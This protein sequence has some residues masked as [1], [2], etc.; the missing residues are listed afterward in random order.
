VTPAFDDGWV[1]DEPGETKLR[2]EPAAP[3]T[4]ARALRHLTEIAR[5]LHSEPDLHRLLDAVLDRVLSLT[6]AE[7]AFLVLRR[8]RSR[9]SIAAS[10]NL[11]QQPIPEASAKIS[12]AIVLST[13]KSGRP[14]LTTNATADPRFSGSDSVAHMR[15]RAVL[16]VPLSVRGRSLGVLYLDNRFEDGAFRGVRMEPIEAFGAQAA[17]AIEHATFQDRARRHAVAMEKEIAERKR[18]EERLATQNAIARL[19]GDAGD[20]RDVVPEMVRILAEGIGWDAGSAWEPGA[21]GGLKCTC[22]WTTPGERLDAFARAIR[23][24]TFPRGEGMPG[25]VWA[26]RKPEWC[27]DVAQDPLHP[28]SGAAAAGLRAAVAVPVTVGVETLGVVAFLS[29]RAHP[30]DPDL[31]EM[32]ANVGAQFG[33][34]VERKR[35]EKAKTQLEAMFRQAQKMDA[36]G[37]LAGG[38]A[39]DFNNLLTVITGYGQLAIAG[40]K[41]GEPMHEYLTEIAEAARRSEAL[42]RQLLVFSRQQVQSVKVLNP[43]EVVEGVQR[44]LR[45]LLGEDVEL[46]VS[47]DRDP[48]CVRV[49]PGQLEQVIV[50]LAVNARDAMPRGGRLHIQTRPIDL[51]EDYLKTR[52]TECRPGR[53]VEIAVTDSGTGIAPEVL[54][55]IFEP[56]FTTKEAGKGTGLGLATVYG[57]VLQSGGL[58]SVYSE[59]GRGASFK[60]F[61]PRVADR[62]VGRTE[63][64]LNPPPARGTESVLVVE[65]DPQLRTLT[66]RL[67]EQQGYRVL[68][69]ESGEAALALAANEEERIDLLLTDLVMPRIG[70]IELGKRLR[71]SRPSL[72]VMYTSGYTGRALEGSGILEN[73][74]T[75][76]EKPFSADA[77][78]RQVRHVL[79]MPM[80]KIDAPPRA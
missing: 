43:N 36:I 52:A 57:I 60:V 22:V 32:L 29:R 38:V 50:N 20:P 62:D 19:L 9:F 37:R 78:A 7:R 48:G 45:R 34:F 18:A 74:D 2:S 49:D 25:R 1:P 17:I 76:I 61:L 65:D 4:E 23:G 15:L 6:H 13:E 44:M 59:P 12:R 30:R 11:D 3:E 70:G 72:R 77:L 31:L 71:E 79:E 67:L 66:R 5:S 53:Y 21:G 47:L 75:F 63:E 26:A 16:C 39:H 28:K 40:T 64:L 73:P 8:D 42:T 80:A 55:H 69:A 14:V 27:E 56:F 24:R 41:P 10:R 54:P 35:Q 68:A 58:V 46:E 51:D 33:Q